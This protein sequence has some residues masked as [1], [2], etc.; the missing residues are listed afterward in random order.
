MSLHGTLSYLDISHLLQVVGSSEK[1]GV[2]E[3]WWQKRRA[4]LF[5]QQGRLVR[6]ESNQFHEG[7]GTLL[8]NAALL[9]PHDLERALANQKEE[10]GERRIGAI[11]CDDFGVDPAAIERLL[12]LQFER[13]VYDVFAWPGGQFE[14]HFQEPE[15]VLDRFN[16][17]PVEFILKVGIRAGFLAEEGVKREQS[18]SGR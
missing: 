6:A 7:I 2:L 18:G 16:L 14:F 8:V 5:F 17:N 9:K 12:R 15:T 3:I 13:I 10:G 1:S 11:L 4:R